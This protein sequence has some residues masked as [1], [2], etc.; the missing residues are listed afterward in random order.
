MKTK[1]FQS[2]LKKK[3]IDFALFYNTDTTRTEANMFYFSQYRGIG[4]L[5]I[6]KNKTPFLI[7]P[8]MELGRE[9]NCKAHAW[10]KDHKLFKSV[11]KRI[12][13]KRIAIDKNLFTINDYKALKK[14][15]RKAKFIDISETISRIRETKTKEEIKIIKRACKISDNILKTAI[16]NLK[17]FRTETELA[18][19]LEYEAKKLG[20]D[21]AFPTVVASGKNSAVPHHSPKNTKLRGFCVIDF[22]IKYKGYCSDTTR[23]VYIGK[24]DKKEKYI[25]NLLLKTQKS[26]IKQ[27]RTGAKCS[28]IVKYV[29]KS[30]S[31]YNKYMTHGLGH[32]FGI[33]IHELPNLKEKSNDIFKENMVF[34]IEPGVYFKNKFGIRI[35]DD[36]LLAKKG[37]EILTKTNKELITI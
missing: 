7:V 10:T 32:G 15:F 28:G 1:E 4:A 35:E 33:N 30:L 17:R 8:E 34:T 20:C 14:Q 3:K 21:L 29:I 27:I 16:K 23:T 11:K 12:K 19:W 13:G 9:K 24:P 26:A 6:P 5:I 25:Y 37:P 2:I 36:I 31:R 18:G 22:G